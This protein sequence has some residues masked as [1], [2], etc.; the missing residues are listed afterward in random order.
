VNLQ[1]RNPRAHDLAHQLANR[2]CISLTEAVIGALEAE[3]KRENAQQ[4]LADRL[5]ALATNLKAKAGKEGHDMSKE[6]IDAMWGHS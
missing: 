2:R 3:L 5:C 1:I 4:P 6:E